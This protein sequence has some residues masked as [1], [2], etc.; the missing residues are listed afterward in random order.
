[1]S[2]AAAAAAA[3]A[4]ADVLDIDDAAC[5][6]CKSGDD[7]SNMLL[8]DGCDHGYHIYC[9]TPKLK[10]I[11]DGDWFCA[12]CRRKRTRQAKETKERESGKGQKRSR[13]EPGSRADDAPAKRQQTQAEDTANDSAQQ[14]DEQEATASE[15]SDVSAA[16]AATDGGSSGGN[17]LPP[18]PPPPPSAPPAGWVG[19]HGA[20]TAAPGR[21]G[22]ARELTAADGW[23]P[24]ESLATRGSAMV[25]RVHS[26]RIRVARKAPTREDAAVTVI[27]P[28]A[29]GASAARCSVICPRSA[30]AGDELHVAWPGGRVQVGVPEGIVA[31]MLF[32][33]SL[34]PSVTGEGARG[35]QWPELGKVLLAT[36]LPE[37][38]DS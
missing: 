29:A 28:L 25:L 6:V 19:Q 11:P 22:G 13:T 33:V 31:G 10:K 20:G 16:A 5:V 3:A 27:S 32:H 21:I 23:T 36:L 34:P 30:K 14:A 17:T 24:R 8:C 15:P 7:D 12:D 38:T 18:P 26:R 1:M 37:C 2:K 4:S 9:C 35:D